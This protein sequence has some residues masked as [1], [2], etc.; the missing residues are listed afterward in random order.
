MKKLHIVYWLLLFSFYAKAQGGKFQIGI[1]YQRTWMVDKQASPLKYKSSEK[2]F[3][4]GY[5]HENASARFDM[6]INGAFGD[7]FPSAFADRQWYNPGFNSDGAHKKDSSI[8][9]G[10]LYSA[11]IKMGYYSVLSPGY[12]KPG[13]NS[14]HSQGYIGGSL[15]NQIY[16]SDNIIRAGWLNSTSVNADYAYRILINTKHH[17]N[18]KLSIPLFAR[19]SRLPYHNTISAGNGDSNVK[20]FFKHGSRVTSIIDFQNIQFD[21]SYEYAMSKSIGIGLQYFGQWLHY[22]YEKPVTF[23]QNNVSV[24]ASVK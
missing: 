4:I 16:Y 11:R 8:I 7:F 23:F 17:I 2:T 19:N 15:N 1:G 24:V 13:N 6:K 20:T 22:R 14:I 9:K 5:E 18:L 10:R 3:L 21:A 12:S